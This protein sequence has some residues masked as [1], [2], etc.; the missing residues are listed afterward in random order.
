MDATTDPTA[1]VERVREEVRLRNMSVRQ[2][3][4][5]GGVSN[6]TWGDYYATG[7]ATPKMRE[8]VARAFDWQLD[9]PENP[10]PLPEAREDQLIKLIAE[11][12][13]K[14]DRLA[15]EVSALRRPDRRSS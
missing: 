2:A 5:A 12:V 10:P 11:R 15:D 9:W 14:V 13:A 8:A 6:T 3:A 7:I 1:A 4:A